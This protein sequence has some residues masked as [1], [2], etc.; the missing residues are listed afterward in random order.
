MKLF[1]IIF[2]SSLF[3]ITSNTFAQTKSIANQ[4]KDVNLYEYYRYDQ[5]GN[6]Y[7]SIELPTTELRYDCPI[8]KGSTVLNVRNSNNG[9]PVNVSCWRCN[10]KGYIVSNS[11]K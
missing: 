8:C 9:V 11:G 1:I 4:A 2:F 10:G 7:K 3:L 6:Y 5:N